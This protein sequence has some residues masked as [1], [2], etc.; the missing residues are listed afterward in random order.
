MANLVWLRARRRVLLGALHRMGA[1]PLTRPMDHG[2]LNAR[3]DAL[4]VFDQRITELE[5][6]L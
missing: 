6:R 4:R 2:L 3:V 5:S 1:E